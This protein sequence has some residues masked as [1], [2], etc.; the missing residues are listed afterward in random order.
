MARKPAI[1]QLLFANDTAAYV[2]DAE[3]VMWQ[4]TNA[5]RLD[6]QLNVLPWD[7]TLCDTSK[8]LPYKVPIP[9]VYCWVE[10]PTQTGQIRGECIYLQSYPATI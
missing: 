5:G 10:I 2:A 6:T 3:K 7:G 9:T 1:T 8:A 4:T